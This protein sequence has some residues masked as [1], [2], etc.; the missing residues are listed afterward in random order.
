MRNISII[1][2]FTIIVFAPLL[3][4]ANPHVA[5]APR[6]A[7]V[8]AT[9]PAEVTAPVA[10]VTAPPAA[11][12]PPPTTP[13]AEIPATGAD[14]P[15]RVSIPSINLDKKIVGVGVNSKNEMAVP[16]GSTDNVGWFKF[17]PKPGEV[18][19]AVLDAHVFAAFADLKYVAPG[20]DIYVETAS[21]ER[22]HFVVEK[23]QT[24]ALADLSPATLFGATSERHLNLITCA[25]Q[26][27]PDHSTYDHRLV[28][29]AAL[30]S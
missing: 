2:G 13:K 18:G 21:G 6:P 11:E 14:T 25:G 12:T 10:E 17:G 23:S 4:V 3:V 27:T 24:Y 5:A 28:L 16:A 29:F 1:F 26:L 22:L 8:A 30:V 7:E 9:L 20:A 15:I 19:S